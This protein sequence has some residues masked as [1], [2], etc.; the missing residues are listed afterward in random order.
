M[1]SLIYFFYPAMLCSTAYAVAPTKASH[2]VSTRKERM[3]RRNRRY[4]RF[5]R[6]NL[7]YGQAGRAARAWIRLARCV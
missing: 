1:D 2:E 4:H 3:M 5:R 7:H 6:M